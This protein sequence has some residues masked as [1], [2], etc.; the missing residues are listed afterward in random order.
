[1]M[2]EDPSDEE[3]TP[4]IDRDLRV[5]ILLKARMRCAFHDARLRVSDVLLVP[6]TC[7]WHWRGWGT[8]TRASSRRALPLCTLCPFGFIRC[9]LGLSALLRTGFDHGVGLRQLCQTVFPSCDLLAS[10]QSI[11]HRSLV[12]LCTPDEAFLDLGSPWRFP[13]PQTLVTHRL[14]FGGIS[15]H[16]GPI[17]A[18]GPEFQHTGPPSQ[19]REP[20]QR[21]PGVLAERDAET[22]PVSHGR[23]ADGLR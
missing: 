14:A 9:L 19:A 2:R 1:M 3:Q 18:D 21:P 6:G 5:V 16:P 12:D 7:S 13:L 20:V 8:T 11:G 10:H 23:G 15:M 22:R 17:Q 4:L